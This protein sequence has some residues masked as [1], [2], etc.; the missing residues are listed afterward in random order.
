MHGLRLLLAQT[1]QYTFSTIETPD[2]IL[3]PDDDILIR[4]RQQADF[5]RE[6]LRY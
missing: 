5:Y 2:A 3:F 4:L 6:H 1:S